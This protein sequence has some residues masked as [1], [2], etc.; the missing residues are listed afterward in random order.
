MWMGWPWLCQQYAREACRWTLSPGC[1]YYPRAPKKPILSLP[2]RAEQRPPHQR[3]VSPGRQ[4]GAHDLSLLWQWTRP[5]QTQYAEAL[6]RRL[7]WVDCDASQ[8]IGS[9]EGKCIFHGQ[10]KETQRAGSL[11]SQRVGTCRCYIS[12]SLINETEL[13]ILIVF[14]FISAHRSIVYLEID[15]R[16][17]YQQST[18]CF[19]SATDVAAFLGALATSGNLNVPYIEAVTSMSVSVHFQCNVLFNFD[20]ICRHKTKW[21]LC[22]NVKLYL[23]FYIYIFLLYL[24]VWDL[25]PRIQS[26]TPC[27]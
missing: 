20:L 18:E 9:G 5:G 19:Q 4:R 11:A 21:P 6:C 2:Q 16:Q 23:V 15:N 25:P 1:P 7:A 12:K 13:C 17:C 14:P 26:S 22:W 8:C 27:M 3:C 24:Q 10:F